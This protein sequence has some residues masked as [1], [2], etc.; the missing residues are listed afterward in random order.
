MRFIIRGTLVLILA[1]LTQCKTCRPIE[2][3]DV[4]M[5]S[6]AVYAISRDV[7]YTGG[8]I[9]G[10]SFKVNKIIT[11]KFLGES[12]KVLVASHENVTLIC[13]R[14]TSS[15]VQL[16][17]QVQSSVVMETITIGGRTMKVM[18]Y[19]ERALQLLKPDELIN[20]SPKFTKRFVITGHSL[21]GALASLFSIYMK[22]HLKW[23][24]PGMYVR[25]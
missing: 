3:E 7:M 23:T 24:N 18:K 25:V 20:S 12:L 10:T 8:T 15:L 6:R 22:D 1:T 14:G 4:R 16:L 21:G 11:A 13:F 9:R 17:H 19:F 5:A 2:L